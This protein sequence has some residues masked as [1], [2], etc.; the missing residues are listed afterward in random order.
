M[1]QRITASA[2]PAYKTE[3][4]ASEK[5]PGR[6]QVHGRGHMRVYQR[7]CRPAAWKFRPRDNPAETAHKAEQH[8]IRGKTSVT[9]MERKGR[10]H[11]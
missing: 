3:S 9:S 8:K 7:M 10:H 1:R 2:Q 5:A 6:F 4:S 11:E